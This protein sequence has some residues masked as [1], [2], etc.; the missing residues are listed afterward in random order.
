[1][2]TELVRCRAINS[3]HNEDSP[4]PCTCC[5]P[6]KRSRRWLWQWW[7]GRV[8]IWHGRIRIRDGGIGLWWLWNGRLWI[9]WRL[10]EWWRRV[11][12]HKEDLGP[13]GPR[14]DERNGLWLWYGI[15]L[16]RLWHGLWLWHGI[17]LWRRYGLWLWHGQRN[18]RRI[19]LWHGQWWMW[20]EHGLWRHGNG[21]WIWRHGNGHGKHGLAK[22]VQKPLRLQ[23]ER[24]LRRQNVL[25][26]S[27]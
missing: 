14:Y 22:E 15:W 10:D 9:R 19:R 12:P 6:D 2:G 25:L 3:R 16:W 17:R 4:A 13:L 18:G 23:E 24:L 20:H 1:M 8:W 21:W 5:S 7:H 11:L 27:I 26:C